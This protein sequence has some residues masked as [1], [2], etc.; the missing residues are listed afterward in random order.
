VDAQAKQRSGFN[1]LNSEERREERANSML[2]HLSSTARQMVAFGVAPPE[3]RR[4]VDRMGLHFQL[5]VE[6]LEMIKGA[7]FA[8]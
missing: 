3:A 8:V 7:A 4:F 5:T 6:Q 2:G 1:A